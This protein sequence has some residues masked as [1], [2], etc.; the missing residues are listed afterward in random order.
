MSSRLC[1]YCR[2]QGHRA[3]K[4][5][6]KAN[7][8]KEILTFV[9]QERKFVLDTMVKRGWGEGATF[10]VSRWGTSTT[11][12]LHNAD[13]ITKWQFG[14]QNR[15]KYSKQLR[16]TPM[17]LIQR[18]TDGS[19]AENKYQYDSAIVSALTFGKGESGINEVRLGVSHM[20][21]PQP[22]PEN[23]TESHGV[24]LIDPSYKPY[25]M[26]PSLYAKNVVVHR[27]VAEDLSRRTSNWDDTYY[28]N[29]IIPA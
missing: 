28:E 10:V 18:H 7:V 21:M 16:F 23:V 15:V 5:E 19:I 1:G 22:M 17:H 25:D 3:D 9:P 12:V 29:G 11:Y 4:C 20:L 13:F 27:R 2:Q 24:Y 8:R 14:T 6:E 26:E